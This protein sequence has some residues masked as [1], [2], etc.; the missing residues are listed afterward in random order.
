M[1]LTYQL[2]G[3][4]FLGRFGLINVTKQ[5]HIIFPLLVVLQ[6]WELL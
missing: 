2:L 6:L 5:I 4:W 1:H 3:E